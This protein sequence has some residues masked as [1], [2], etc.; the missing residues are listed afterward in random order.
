MLTM[1]KP[2]KM[3]HLFTIRGYSAS[4]VA[5]KS[6]IAAN[7]MYR[8]LHGYN[9][10][11]P[12]TLK[13]IADSIGCK[14]S[15]F[16]ETERTNSNFFERLYGMFGKETLQRFFDKMDDETLLH[17]WKNY[18]CDVF[19]NGA[20]EEAVNGSAALIKKKGCDWFLNE[21]NTLLEMRHD[22]QLNMRLDENGEIYIYLPEEEFDHM[23]K[24]LKDG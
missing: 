10:P 3:K 20:T 13:A 23:Q 22:Y 11:K 14:V 15:D 18:L 6:G 1:F 4:A 19:T 9:V 12:E 2:E 16:Y 17:F 8:I 7:T 21:L 5:K 24:V